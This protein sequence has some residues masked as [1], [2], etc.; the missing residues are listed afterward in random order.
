MKGGVAFVLAVLWACLCRPTFAGAHGSE[1][2]LAKVAFPQRGMVEVEITA[3]YGGG[4]PMIETEE[5]AA[6]AIANMLQVHKGPALVPLASFGAVRWEKR[7]QFDP[8]SPY[9]A[10]SGKEEGP[11]RL[12]TGIWSWKSAD[13]P[14]IFAVPNGNPQNVVLWTAG[15]QSAQQNSKWLYLIAGDFSPPIAIPG[16]RFEEGGKIAGAVVISLCVLTGAIAWRRN[17]RNMRRI[18]GATALPAVH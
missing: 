15:P 2:L 1:F 16:N 3:D 9:A 14:L 4:N 8:T 17:R 18:T 6:S 12:L 11:H 10:L 13:V 7:E 5:E